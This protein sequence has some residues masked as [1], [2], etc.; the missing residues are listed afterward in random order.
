MPVEPW[1]SL[2]LCRT[3][4][5]PKVGLVLAATAA[6]MSAQGRLGPKG[7]TMRTAILLIIMTAFVAACG[8]SGGGTPSGPLDVNLTP[9]GASPSTFSALS[10]ATLRFVNPGSF[11][12]RG[13]FT[14]RAFKDGDVYKL[15]YGGADTFGIC[16]GINS[17]HWRIGLAQSADG[18]NWTRVPGTETGGAILDN[19][20]ADKFDS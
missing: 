7:T 6:S 16:S 5:I 14:V 11:D 17:A 3:A 9:S 20:A 10:Q 8:G 4:G 12:E 15:Y 18:L 1:R 2:H 13:N 19:G